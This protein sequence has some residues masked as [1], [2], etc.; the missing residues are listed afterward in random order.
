MSDE[1]G[2]QGT[3][4]DGFEPVRDEFAP[5]TGEPFPGGAAPGNERLAAAVTRAA[6]AVGRG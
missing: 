3:V 2:V 5:L 6:P 4:A 1:T